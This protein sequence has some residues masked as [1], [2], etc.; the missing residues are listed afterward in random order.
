MGICFVKKFVEFQTPGYADT[1]RT[2]DVTAGVSPAG[3]G[4]PTSGAPGIHHETDA[5]DF[6]PV[7]SYSQRPQVVVKTRDRALS[8]PNAADV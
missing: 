7:F 1:G 4:E 8:S 2:D 3:L 6:V 5:F